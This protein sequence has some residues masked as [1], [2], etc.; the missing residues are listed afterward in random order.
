MKVGLFLTNQQRLE[1]DMVKALDEQ[2]AMVHAARDNG[3]DSLFCG[4]HYLNDC[5]LPRLF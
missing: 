1:T 2:I 5:R 4:Q 3:W